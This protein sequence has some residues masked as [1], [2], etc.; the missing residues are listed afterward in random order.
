[1]DCSRGVI[2]KCLPVLLTESL[3]LKM[4]V[5]QELQLL[6]EPGK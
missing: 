2:P 1:M 4:A 6:T 3:L 5:N